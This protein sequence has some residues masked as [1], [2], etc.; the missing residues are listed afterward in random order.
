MS[1]F[2]HLL[3]NGLIEFPP[4]T[5][6]ILGKRIPFG[7]GGYFRLYP[8]KF[9]KSLIKRTNILNHPCMIYMHP[10]EVGP[11]IPDIPN[12]SPYRKFRHYYNSKNG[13]DRLSNLLSDFRFGTAR[14]V[15]DEQDNLNL[16]KK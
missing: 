4:S 12:M 7:G 1:P 6:N 2:I 10:Y 13:F 16:N 8:L 3:P 11:I 15:I 5:I 9:T 14:E